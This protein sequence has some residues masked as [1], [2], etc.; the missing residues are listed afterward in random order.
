MP[1]RGTK[2]S[3]KTKALVLANM[4]TQLAVA[5]QNEDRTLELL[6]ATLGYFT[7]Q[8]KRVE[9]INFN[10]APD[11]TD[12]VIRTSQEERFRC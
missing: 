5:S 7:N 3:K 11:G 10:H 6:K 8:G 9:S 1:P 4:N 2:P 12:V